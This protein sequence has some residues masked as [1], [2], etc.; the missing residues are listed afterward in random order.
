VSV[1]SSLSTR[2]QSLYKAN[3]KDTGFLL[4]LQ[5]NG[6]NTPS[7]NE[8]KRKHTLSSQEFS[9]THMNSPLLLD[10]SFGVIWTFSTL[11]MNFQK[12]KIFKIIYPDFGYT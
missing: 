10:L 12:Y 5:I 8:H 7:S 1:H 11:K 6:V 3:H 4:A 9:S 2:D